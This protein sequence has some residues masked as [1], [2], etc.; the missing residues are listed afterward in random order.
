MAPVSEIPLALDPHI[1]HIYIS[2]DRVR[3]MD[4]DITLLGDCDIVVAELSKRLDWNLKHHMLP[5]KVD[6]VVTEVES[7]IGVWTV[8]PRLSAEAVPTNGAS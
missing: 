7:G 6:N 2:R 3:H 4:M 1:P 8:K 5:A